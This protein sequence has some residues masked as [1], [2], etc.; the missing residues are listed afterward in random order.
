MASPTNSLSSVRSEGENELGGGN[1]SEVVEDIPKM[2]SKKGTQCNCADVMTWERKL[3]HELAET[4]SH[5]KKVEENY[6]ALDRSNVVLRKKLAQLSEEVRRVQSELEHTRTLLEESKAQVHVSSP[7]STEAS[8]DTLFIL[9]RLILKKELRSGKS[10]IH[11]AR[12]DLI[13]QQLREASASPGPS[14]SFPWQHFA[15]AHVLYSPITSQREVKPNDL[16][17]LCKTAIGAASFRKSWPVASTPVI[18]DH[19]NDKH[20]WV[21]VESKTPK[22]WE[23]KVQKK[24]E[25]KAQKKGK[26]KVKRKRRRKVKRRR[27]WKVESKA[28]KELKGLKGAFII[29]QGMELYIRVIGE[30]ERDPDTLP[31]TLGLSKYELLPQPVEEYIFKAVRSVN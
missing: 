8:Y 10:D 17:R 20:A 11:S 9:L 27:K 13:Q 12:G 26:G 2:R 24:G 30:Y 23:C 5:V 21:Q 4:L 14:S 6:D 18:V 31:E 15:L 29:R 16:K 22:K 25:S 1:D 3:M 28:Q 19:R 7:P